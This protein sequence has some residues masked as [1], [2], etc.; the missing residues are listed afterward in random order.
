MKKS[1]WMIRVEDISDGGVSFEAT[2]EDPALREI[3]QEAAEGRRGA[4]EGSTSLT[5]EPWPSRLDIQGR[6]EA[7][8]PLQCSRC[9][10][11]YT[12]AIEREFTQIL[13]RV[14]DPVAEEEIELSGGDLDRGVLEG[15]YLDLRGVLREELLLSLPSKP[16]CK[17]DCR[18]ICPGCGAELNDAECTCPPVIDERWAA[19][20]SLK[21]RLR[22]D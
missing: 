10:E 2:A 13:T 1:R 18:G 14:V 15:E 12:E 20:A 7:T 3:L 9:L 4:I 22:G 11:E 6:L 17:E 8:V 16:L 5:L 21:G 19:L